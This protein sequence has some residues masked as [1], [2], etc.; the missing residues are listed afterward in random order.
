MTRNASHAFILVCGLCIAM[1]APRSA[2]AQ[3]VE[4]FY[5]GRSVTMLVGTSPGGINDISARLVARHLVALHSGRPQHRGPE[6]SRR[7]RPR[8][9]EPTLFQLG[10][11]R[12]GAGQARARRAAARHPGQ[13]QRP[14]R[15]GEIQ[16][17]RQPVIL[18]GRRLSDA[19]QRHSSRQ[20][21]RRSQ[22]AGSAAGAGR[23]QLGV[24]QP[25]FCGHRQGGARP[26]RECR[27]RLY[28]RGAVVSRHAAQRARR[29]DGGL[30]L[31]AYRPA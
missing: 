25:D 15:S 10:E 16:L 11:G 12:L 1:T 7:R 30:E 29:P 18:C 9:R 8:H 27:A 20:D 28:R 31:G 21:R 4:T 24:K 14:V 17:A 23:R 6:Q 26:Q 22:A 5:K 19:R 2:T 3:S 13:C